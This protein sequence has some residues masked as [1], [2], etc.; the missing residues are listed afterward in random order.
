MARLGLDL[1]GVSELRWKGNGHFQS[2]DHKI[3]Y[4]GSEKKRNG[5]AIICGRRMAASILGFNPVSDRM[6]TA[7]FQG[8]PIHTSVVQVYAPTAESEEI[9]HDEF[10]ESLQ[11][12]L[13]NIPK[14]DMVLV[15]G[16]FNAN[17]GA[18]EGD[19][20]IGRYGLGS[21]NE[22][23]DR[24]HECCAAND[25]IVAN[26]FYKQ[27]PRR[28]YTWTALDCKYRNQIESIMIKT[29]WK[30]AISSVKT[31]PGTDCGTDHELIIAYLKLRLKRVQTDRIIKRYDLQNIPDAYKVEVRN[32][33]SAINLVEREPEEMW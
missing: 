7:R 28:I 11:E 21:R 4:S 10:Y 19:Q 1:L 8:N 31:R 20:Y 12:T 15:M 33:F 27:P 24:L 18:G 5:V 22:S 29:R 13:I 6:I 9:V 32:M 25:L 30:S 14:R 23:E 3:L 17:V 16:D 26:S 2:G